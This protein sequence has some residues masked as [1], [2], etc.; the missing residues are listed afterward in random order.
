[1]HRLSVT[2]QM[3]LLL[4]LLIALMGTLSGAAVAQPTPPETSYPA[5]RDTAMTTLEM[6]A[7]AATASGMA[8][9][10]LNKSYQALKCHFGSDSKLEAS[11]RAWIAFRDADRAFWGGGGGSI[12]RMNGE[13]CRANLSDARAKELDSWP[14]NSPRD[15]LV[16]CR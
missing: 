3:R 5:C 14:P 2:P 9:E 11:Q 7:C 16:P 1:M 15:A 8:E 10:R 6:T 13:Y 12:A 4:A